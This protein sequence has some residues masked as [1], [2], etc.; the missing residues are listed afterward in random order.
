MSNSG[1]DAI[2]MAPR[3]CISPQCRLCGF[4][5]E[6]GE[7]LLASTKTG[8]TGELSHGQSIYDVPLRVWLDPCEGLCEH[9]EGQAIGCHS[10]CVTFLSFFPP[11]PLLEAL[12]FSYQLLLGAKVERQ[13]RI[14]WVIQEAL[15]KSQEAK[16]RLPAEVWLEIAALLTREYVVATVRDAWLTRCSADCRVTLSAG[17]WARYVSIGG[18]DYIADLTSTPVNGHGYKQIFDAKSPLPIDQLYVSEDHLGTRQIFF[19][20][21]EDP[22]PPQLPKPPISGHHRQESWWR[23]IK[24]SSDIIQAK[25]DGLK[26]RRIGYDTP[27]ESVLWAAPMPSCD[28]QSLYYHSLAPSSTD[29]TDSLYRLTSFPCNDHGNTGYSAYWNG[30]L[31]ALYAHRKDGTMPSYGGI[32]ENYKYDVWLYMPLND[33]E[34]ICDIWKRGGSHYHCTALLLKTNQDRVAVLGPHAVLRDFSPTWSH[35]ARPSNAPTPIYFNISPR[36]IHWLA[37]GQGP[38]D[39][40]PFPEINLTPP[41][42]RIASFD[43]FLTSAVLDDVVEI[44]PCRQKLATHSPIIGL[45][46]HYGNGNRACLGQFRFDCVGTPVVVDQTQKLRLGFA[47]ESSRYPYVAKMAFHPAGQEV[48]YEWIELSWRGRVDWWFSSR[49]CQVFY[50][51]QASFPLFQ[52]YNWMKVP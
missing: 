27:L 7:L 4:D 10:K 44:I 47:R 19:S 14:S 31:M 48:G 40:T 20:R 46:L 6:P 33:D 5:F 12:A 38:D 34:W 51:G 37:L 45:L 17:V 28:A 35:I 9:G 26:I 43:L 23:T 22:I 11:R 39:S 15:L 50:D 25:S 8:R 36:S 2:M 29:M 41:P 42:C 3:L 24:P 21:T 1:D 49:N 30:R 52:R 32:D 18:V 13:R 16:L